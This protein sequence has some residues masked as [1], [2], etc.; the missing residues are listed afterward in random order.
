MGHSLI[1][2]G[3]EIQTGDT[4][5][6]VMPHNHKHV[7]ATYHKAGPKEVQ[8]AIDAAVKAQ[9]ESSDIALGGES[10]RYDAHCRTDFYQVP[11]RR[12]C[13]GDVGAK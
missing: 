3:K 10:F 11:V 1:I 12:E 9:K 7:L 2:G 5:K 4:G 6:V 13:L 8:M